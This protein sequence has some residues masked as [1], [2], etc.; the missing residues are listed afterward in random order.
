MCNE[1]VKCEYYKGEDYPCVSEATYRNCPLCKDL[2]DLS[3][4]SDKKETEL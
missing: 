2:F 3:D 1:C 4:D